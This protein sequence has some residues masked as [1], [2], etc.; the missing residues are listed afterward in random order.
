MAFIDILKI[1]IAIIAFCAIVALCVASAYYAKI[2]NV[3]WTT[4]IA[5]DQI[6]QNQQQQQ[7]QQ[8]Q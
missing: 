1:V 3:K 4:N 6:N 2:L 7:Q 8:Q 5:T